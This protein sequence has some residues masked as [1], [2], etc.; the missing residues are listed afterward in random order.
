M[1]RPRWQRPTKPVPSEL[2]CRTTLLT[3]TAVSSTA[4][5]EPI[6]SSWWKPPRRAHR[7]PAS[8]RRIWVLPFWRCFGWRAAHS[9]VWTVHRR[10]GRRPRCWRSRYAARRTTRPARAAT[11][12]TMPCGVDER[13]LPNRA[14]AQKWATAPDRQPRARHA[15]V[16][17]LVQ[18]PPALRRP[19]PIPPTEFGTNHCSRHS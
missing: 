4:P 17:R 12:M 8:R 13:A 3:T 2:W 1:R 10:K 5:G 16:G 7:S 6:R 18:P 9:R 11:V 15:R 19:R 14:R